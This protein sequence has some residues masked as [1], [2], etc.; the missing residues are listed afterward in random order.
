VG[1]SVAASVTWYIGDQQGLGAV[2]NLSNL[3]ED[4]E[5]AYSSLKEEIEGAQDL[6]L[7]R[8]AYID[9]IQCK[10]PNFHT[11]QPRRGAGLPK[12][13]GFRHQFPTLTGLQGA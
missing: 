10:C 5:V 1:S 2:N 12:F 13:G 3:E 6:R 11:A 9:H 8:K 7:L 4:L